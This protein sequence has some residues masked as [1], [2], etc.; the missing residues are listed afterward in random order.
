VSH[1]RTLKPAAPGGAQATLAQAS[2]GQGSK[3]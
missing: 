1:V 2:G 3:P